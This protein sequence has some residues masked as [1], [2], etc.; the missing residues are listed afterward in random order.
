MATEHDKQL[1]VMLQR[2]KTHM[3]VTD[4]SKNRPS[5]YT[6]LSSLLF[7]FEKKAGLS[8]AAL[9]DAEDEKRSRAERL[10]ALCQKIVATSIFRPKTKTHSGGFEGRPEVWKELLAEVDPPQR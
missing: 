3:E 7:T 9:R 2:A 6:E 1:A 10:L 8:A 4:L 5:V